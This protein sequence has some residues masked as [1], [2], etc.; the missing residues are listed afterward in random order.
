V[1][2]LEPIKAAMEKATP[3][4]WGVCFSK[5][6][7]GDYLYQLEAR[8]AI[9]T[10]Q[11]VATDIACNEDASCIVT[12]HNA[13]PAMIAEIERLRAAL[14]AAN[15]MTAEHISAVKSGQASLQDEC[16]SRLHE[17]RLFRADTNSHRTF[18]SRAALARYDADRLSEVADFI[19]AHLKPAS[20]GSPV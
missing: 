3:G 10:L 5:R 1:I 11:C 15:K 6:L 8:V 14:Q 16:D 12:L 20:E 18:L 4:E 2:D 9:D 17:A 7:G 19:C 13:A